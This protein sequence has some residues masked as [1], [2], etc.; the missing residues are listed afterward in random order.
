MKEN[1]IV[2]QNLVEQTANPFF[3]LKGED[4]VLESANSTVFNLWN[5]GEEAIGKPLLEIVPQLK[6][7]PILDW[8]SE[9]YK[10]GISHIGNEESIQLILENGDVE[11]QYF[12]HI[13]QP[14]RA[15]DNSILG[16]I[17][18]SYKVTQQVNSRKYQES[19]ASWHETLIQ[20]LPVAVC[21]CD[22]N[23]YIQLYNKAA[24]DL[25]GC[26]PKV[27]TVKYCGSFRLYHADGTP[28]LLEKSP[29]AVILQTGS[30]Q[31]N[32]EII[33]ER[34]D[35]SKSHV[36]NYPQLIFDEVGAVTGAIN[37]LIDISKQKIVEIALTEAKVFAEMAT[38]IA[39]ESRLKAQIA[40][41]LA[42]A[43][44]ETKQQFLS[45]MS[46]EIRT[47]MNSIIGFAKVMMKTALTAK[48][49]EYL[50]AIKI[51]GDA[52][53]VLIN[54]ILDLAK[55]DAGKMIFEETPFKM[56]VTLPAMLHLFELKIKEKNLLFIH[57]YDPKIPSILVGD[58][59][60]LHQIILNL[61][62]NAIK[63]TSEGKITV[64]VQLL[65]ENSTHAV[66][67]FSVTDTGIGIPEDQIEAIFENFQQA[68]SGTVRLYGG[69][70]LGLAIAKQLVE[71]QG[72]SIQVESKLGVGSTFSFNLKFQK[73]SESVLLESVLD[74]LDSDIKNIKVLIVEDMPLN[75]LLMK[76]LL[77]DFGFERDIA[78]NGRI[79]IEKLHLK[80]Y[81]IIL[82]DLQMP[83]M[84]GYEATEYIRNTLHSK[85]PII[86]LTAD[87]TTADLIRC[88]EAGMDDYIS[89]PVDERLLYGKIIG[90]VM[91]PLLKTIIKH[92]LNASKGQFKYTDLN[93]L[94]QRTRNN[95]EMIRDIIAAY[96]EQTP[97]LISAM[98]TSLQNQ[99]WES[100]HAAAH[101][102]IPSF[103]ILGMSKDFEKMAKQVMEYARS[104][105][106]LDS[107]SEMV[108]QLE[109]VCTQA[110]Q[111]LESEI[112]R[113]KT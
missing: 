81:D 111:E 9:V 3:I 104:R 21:T 68:S 38:M 11:T 43:A 62:S 59:V 80:T 8:L 98:K 16:I 65:E 86:A 89:K 50:S 5:V 22:I 102:M 109:A 97:P 79:A 91:K 58:P 41:R 49:K 60:R 54:D 10:T 71:H 99:D 101:K 24:S 90:L 30:V 100:L 46:H 42:E 40:T 61:V 26:E 2:F 1:E 39:E 74:D 85:I 36:L 112:N 33:M 113:F 84:N 70:G 35:G 75:Q 94:I 106:Q 32:I 88:K 87:V 34:L 18:F 64:G 77:D 31:D 20:S 93:Y 67:G 48:Q 103:S 4:M 23:G 108:L 15:Q 52:L 110:C 7:Q 17:V 19:K 78:D 29:M 83:E 25:W 51:S 13:Y 63:F 76:T 96:L 92:D 45:N 72:G 37:T 95:P 57:E 69:T 56:S 105:Q 12:N 14:Y 73:A 6:G 47:P 107:I 28:L 53:I 44:V 27:G 55:V 82:M 66:I